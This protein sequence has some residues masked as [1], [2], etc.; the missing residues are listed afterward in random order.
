MNKKA[1]DIILYGLL[2]IGM[3]VSLYL[4]FQYAPPAINPTNNQ[5]WYEQ[6]IF[7]VHVSSAWTGFLAF[8]VVAVAS[9]IFLRNESR[10]ADLVAQTSAEI[11]I[12]FTTLTLISG[13][14]WAKSFWGRYWDWS[15]PR[16]VTAL[17]LWFLYI[18]YLI[19]RSSVG[20]D[21]RRARFAAVFGIIAFLDVPIVFLSV[22][23]Y[24]ASHPPLLVF[25]P[26]GLDPSMKVAFFFTLFIF[27]VFYVVLLRNALRIKLLQDELNRLKEV[28]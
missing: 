28:I 5:T 3:F 16:L 18:G 1:L 12:V 4:I 19:L 22:R 20:E 2:L 9:I 25:E 24:R 8:F 13:P 23:W 10:I 7:Y 21:F 11:G 26:G 27:T 6:K 17:I 14:L 15:E